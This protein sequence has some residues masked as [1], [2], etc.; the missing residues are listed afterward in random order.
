MLLNLPRGYDMS[1]KKDVS[2]KQEHMIASYLGWHVVSGSGARACRP[3][4][5]QSDQ[6]LGECKTHTTLTPR[7]TFMQAVWN[8]LLDEASSRFKYPVLFVDDGTQKADHTWCLLKFNMIDWPSVVYGNSKVITWF[9]CNKQFKSNIVISSEELAKLYAD[10][11][12]TPTTS[13]LRIHHLNNDFLLVSLPLFR[14]IC[15][16]M[17]WSA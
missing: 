13:G 9:A 14:E 11:G 8:K 5:V 12:Q 1:D 3:G 15:Q 16:A 17:G 10:A 4:D 2:S 6:W 7:Y